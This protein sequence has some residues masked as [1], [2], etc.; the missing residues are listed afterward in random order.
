MNADTKINNDLKKMIVA[1]WDI[2]RRCR[3]NNYSTDRELLAKAR[4][5][6]V[7]LAGLS[8]P[9]EI[10]DASE[11]YVNLGLG[12][13]ITAIRWCS[14]GPVYGWQVLFIEAREPE[15]V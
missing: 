13:P 10:G 8:K 7:S 2:E 6:V 14:G 11:M 9:P 15:A 3:A 4:A 5:K 12:F 1:C